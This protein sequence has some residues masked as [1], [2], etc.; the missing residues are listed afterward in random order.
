MDTRPAEMIAAP[1]KLAIE[2]C[3]RSGAPFKTCPNAYR[4]VFTDRF[5]GWRGDWRSPRRH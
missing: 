3:R 4:T 2:R 1:A 5:Y